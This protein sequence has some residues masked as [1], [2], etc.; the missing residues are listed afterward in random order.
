MSFDLILPFL[1]PIA[2]LILDPTVSEIMVNGSQ[3]VF[4]ERDGV[5]SPVDSVT[6]EERSLKVAVKN[7][8]RLLGDDVSEE[9]PIL[10]A[11][12]PDG[13]RVAAVLPPCSLGGTTLTIRKFQSR[14][15][16]CEE[17]V[18]VGML[19]DNVVELVRDAL[20]NRDNILISGGTGTGKTTL[21]NALATLLPASDRVVVIEET[22]EL[23]LT[24]PNLVRLEAR[25]VQPDAPAVTIR[26][27]LRATLR[28]RPDRIIVG[29]V[30][31][32]E[33]FDLLQTLNTG[34]SG[35][36]STIHANSAELALARFASCVLQSGIDLPYAAI[37]RLISESIDLVIHLERRRGTRSVSEL[38][39]VMGY[40]SERD[41]YELQ[42][43]RRS[44]DADAS[45]REEH[46]PKC[47][48][49]R[50]P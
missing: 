11:R 50:D 34:H 29:E 23:Q 35:S 8:A 14:F 41:V 44:S 32:G 13:S 9:V 5:V 17:L 37:R 1:R 31:G 7:I 20:A 47:S 49:R 45:Q 33:A 46:G 28:H 30:R 26:D 24:H 6:I 19:T 21:L 27:L 22:A 39:S 15:W 4:V 40:Q 42:A 48:V 38:I 18:R 3:R 16:T 36:L 25:R 43:P 12:L 10:D 2:D